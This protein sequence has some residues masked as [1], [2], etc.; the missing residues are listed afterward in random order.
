ME[1]IAQTTTVTKA[2]ST[3]RNGVLSA[4]CGAPG[5]S[6][7]DWVG[8]I[9]KVWARGSANTFDLAKVVA[10]AKHRLA[11]GGWNQ[12]WKSH[13]MPFSKRK[14]AML[15]VIGTKLSSLNEQTFAHLPSGWSILYQL[16]LLDSATFDQLIQ[17]GTIHPKLTLREAKAVLG[18]FR[19]Q[20]PKAESRKCNV[21]ERLRKFWEFIDATLP[22]WSAEEREWAEEELIQM[23]EEIGAQGRSP[24]FQKASGAGQPW[25]S[26]PRRSATFDLPLIQFPPNSPV[27]KTFSANHRPV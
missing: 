16:A 4:E 25:R 5:K 17:D 13:Q 26:P 22:G 14:G 10:V 7:A 20:R 15:A 6:M 12:L 8:E 1:V 24:D 23:A 18:K 27:S 3:S 9:A 19:G 2:A 21:K 11:Y